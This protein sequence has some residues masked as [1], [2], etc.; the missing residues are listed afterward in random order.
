MPPINTMQYAQI[1]QKDLDRVMIAMLTSGWM[2]ANAGQVIYTGGNTIKIPKIAMSGLGDYDRDN[3]YPTGAASLDFESLTFSMDRGAMFQLDAQ[4]V[5][6]T[7]FA[8]TAGNV[9]GEFQRTMVVP[10]VDAY[11]YSKLAAIAIEASQAATGYTLNSTPPA[12]EAGSLDPSNIFE[13]LTADIAAVQDVIGENE[14]IVVIMSILAGNILNN[15]MKV[16]HYIEIGDG[17]FKSGEVETKVKTLNGVPLLFVPSSRM[18]TA[19]TYADGITAGQTSGGFAPAMGAKQ[20]HWIITSTRAAIAVT[21]TDIIRIFDPQTNQKANAW[22]LD[23]RK[24]HDLWVPDN[25]KPSLYAR[26]A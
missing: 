6:E 23:Y 17:S 22:R 15:A 9:M 10:E 16:N 8:A 4:D 21:K 2:E 1:F 5:D 3:G 26:T 11:R 24:Y 18:K 19:Y 12:S 7:N 14:P 25:K 20:V 13:Y